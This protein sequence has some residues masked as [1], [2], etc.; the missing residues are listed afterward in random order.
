MKG[1]YRLLQ[2]E[3]RREGAVLW[4]GPAPCPGEVGRAAARLETWAVAGVRHG[5]GRPLGLPTLHWLAR[6]LARP[7]WRWI[8]QQSWGSREA[9]REEGAGSRG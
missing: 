6:G 9:G 4:S 7:A 5:A 3:S 2:P 8:Q 1:G